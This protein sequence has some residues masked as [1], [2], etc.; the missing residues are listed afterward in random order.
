ME[1]I[2]H[3]QK[4][5]LTSDGRLEVYNHRLASR[6]NKFLKFYDNGDYSFKEGEEGLFRLSS[7][8]IRL[9]LS[10]FLTKKHV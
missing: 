1:T 3:T 10:K 9:I 5:W 6:I 8:Q 7:D 4:F 2:L